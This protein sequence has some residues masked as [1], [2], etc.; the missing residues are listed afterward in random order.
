MNRVITA[1]GL[2]PVIDRVFPFEEA[3][4]AASYMANGAH[5]GKIIISH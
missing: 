3:P 1:H 2:R 5:F 4:A